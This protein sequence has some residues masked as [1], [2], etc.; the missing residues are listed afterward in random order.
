MMNSSAPSE[1]E[2][3]QIRVQGHLDSR[4]SA[5]FSGLT[6]T[7]EEDGE[8]TL[9]GLVR[10]QA[11]LHGVLAKVRDLGLRLIAVSRIASGSQ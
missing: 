9:S 10:D 5:W 11:A 4:W 8:T 1:P 6:L 7:E 3:Y 2:F